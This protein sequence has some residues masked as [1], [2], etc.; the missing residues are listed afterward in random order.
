MGKRER[1]NKQQPD[2]PPVGPLDAVLSFAAVISVFGVRTIAAP[3]VHED[4]SAAA[5]LLTG[6]VLLA[7]GAVAL[8]LSLAR[9]LAADRHTKRSFDFLVAVAGLLVAVLPGTTLALCADTTMRCHTAMLPFARVVGV[10]LIAL[11]IVC[12]LTVDREVP[13]GR[14][15]RR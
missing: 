7:I 8:A 10:A 15:R 11:S 14:K 2:R 9:L 3:C 6:R 5:C 4:G 1:R 12:E 13:T